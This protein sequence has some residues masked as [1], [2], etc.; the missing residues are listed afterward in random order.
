M[1]LETT[2]LSKE[3][4]SC[5][6]CSARKEAKC[7]VPG[8]GSSDAKIIFIGRNPGANEDEMNRPFIGRAGKLLDEIIQSF[9]LKRKDCAIL[10]T[11]KC[12]TAKNRAPT[13][14][15]IKICLPWLKKELQF[16]SYKRVLIPLGSE[17]FKS[18]FDKSDLKISSAVGKAF[19]P[20]GVQ[21]VTIP[22]YH[23][24]YLLRNPSEKTKMFNYTL[25]RV[26]NYL[27]KEMPEIFV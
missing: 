11:V 6:G 23:P 7:P 9:N 14:E 4:R 17:A 19:R 26:F 5:K 25:P 21:F 24:A 12:Y 1:N 27:C 20:S 15:E 3:I 16:F 8:E 18:L 13:P 2:D 10:N 22:L